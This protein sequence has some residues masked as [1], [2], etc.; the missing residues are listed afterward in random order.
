MLIDEIGLH[1]AVL[2][3]AGKMGSGISLLLLQEIA[4]RDD[5]ILTLY[6]TNYKG[7][8][9]LKEYLRDHLTKYAEK[10][11][12]RLRK[13]YAER[14]DLIDNA[15]MIQ[16]YVI[17]ALDRVRYVA[18]AEECSSANLIFEAIIE[19]VDAKVELFK[20][21]DHGAKKNPFY[22][23]NT[24][25]IPISILQKKGD[26][27]DRII[28]YHFYN[29][30]AVQKLLEIIIPAKIDPQLQEL[31]LNLGERLKK[32]VVMSNDIAGFIGNGHFIR[33]VAAACQKE[34]ALNK[35]MSQVEAIKL[36]NRI[37]QNYMLRP[38]GI[39]QLIDYVGI[40]VAH[41][42][43]KIMTQYL[44]GHEFTDPLI[45]SMVK[46][47]VLGGQNPDGSQKAGFFKYEKGK[48][49]AV[50]DI[51]RSAYVALQDENHLELSW[52]TL[53]KDN[54]RREKISQF[55]HKLWQENS[56]ESQL[57]QEFLA[58][59][60]AIAHGLVKDGVAR[61]IKDV[62]TVLQNGFFHLYGV[63]EPFA[64]MNNDIS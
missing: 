57:T 29:P 31:A 2:G 13:K 55:F 28:G 63:D 18:A 52:K 19:N 22:L 58:R 54:D 48:P 37:T 4:D 45:D 26:L 64:L 32:T 15:E 38:M 25:S 6:D 42:I 51:E 10:E 50:Y 11:I 39:F 1:M 21:I 17:E 30:P 49:V 36:I 47:G 24:S 16:T 40:D 7:F 61:S 27:R 3:A 53:A 62:D 12:N 43:A 9:F 46:A 44:P 60:Q 41:H 34:R 59:S 14:E 33:E 5:T 23:T 56:L 8:V 35:K 20:R